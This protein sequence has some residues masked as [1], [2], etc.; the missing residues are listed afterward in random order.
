MKKYIFALSIGLVFASSA[1][2]NVVLGP[3]TVSN[4]TT[5]KSIYSGVGP[6]YVTFD[7]TSMT[8]CNGNQAGYLQPTWD[9]AMVAAGGAVNDAEGNRMLSVL[10]AAKAT[11]ANIQVNFRVNSNGTGWNKC[12]ISGITLL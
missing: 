7:T 8:G 5:V 10:L 9:A 12:A 2:A 6:T 3:V 1:Q 4:T 11:S